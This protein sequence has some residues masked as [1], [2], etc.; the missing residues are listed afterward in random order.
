LH[1]KQG[2][3]MKDIF[4]GKGMIIN[5]L[6][7]ISPADVYTC[8]QQGAVIIDVREEFMSHVKTFDVKDIRIFPLRTF[9]EDFHL[10]PT[11]MALIFADATG[12]KSKSAAEYARLQGLTQIANLAGGLLEWERDGMPTITY[13][14][15]K[16]D[17]RNRCEFIHKD[18]LK[19]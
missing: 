16:V 7:H 2:L 11:G 3:D 6:K 8:C 15:I 5:Q 13:Q 12:V 4:E 10:L 19:K 14:T 17:G 18:D 1:P 9:K